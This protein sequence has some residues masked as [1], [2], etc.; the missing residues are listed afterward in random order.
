MAGF[1]NTVESHLVALMFEEGRS[2][3]TFAGC[4]TILSKFLP[5]VAIFENVELLGDP[6][7]SHTAR[8]VVAASA[9]NLPK[10]ISLAPNRHAS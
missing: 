2:G 1:R 4:M 3:A 8:S 7:S 9:A 6:A 5:R 10:G